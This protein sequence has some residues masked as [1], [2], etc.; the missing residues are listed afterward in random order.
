MKILRK[1]K[2]K[3]EEQERVLKND[4]KR[5][6]VSASAGSG[7]TYVVI[8]Y[9]TKLICEDRVPVRDFV[10]LTFTKAAASE[11]KER[12]Q[13]KFETNGKRSIYARTN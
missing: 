5:M 12:L 11:M 2:V 9:L 10:V 1:V 6:L 3:I 4:K 8:K 13:K 7:K